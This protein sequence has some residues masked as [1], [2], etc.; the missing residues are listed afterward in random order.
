MFHVGQHV[1]CIDAD[2]ANELVKGCVYTVTGV[3]EVYREID[4][5]GRPVAISLDLEEAEPN[6]C[7]SGFNSIRFRPLSSTRLDVF[8]QLLVS[9]KERVG[10]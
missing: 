10:A 5:L 6:P 9:P 3:F 4:V 1:E 2:G 8:R 7:T